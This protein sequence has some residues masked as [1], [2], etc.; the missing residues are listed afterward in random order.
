MH[1]IAAG[2]LIMLIAF[3]VLSIMGGAVV[4][5][6]PE[7]IRGELAPATPAIGAV[8]VAIVCS[9][10]C[11][12][13]P[14][15]AFAVPLL[16]L[17]L[18]GLGI[19]LQRQRVSARRPTNWRRAAASP[20]MRWLGAAG[21]AACAPI[22]LASVTA[23]RLGTYVVSQPTWSNDAFYYVSVTDWLIS[24]SASGSPVI[25][26][27]GDDAV[28]PGYGP[29][30]SA[31]VLG[32]RFSHEGVLSFLTMFTGQP[33]TS[34]WYPL[35][36]LWLALVPGSCAAAFSLLRLSRGHGLIAGVVLS[37][38]AAMLTQM[39]NQNS[40]SLLGLCIAPLA[41]S[42]LTRMLRPRRGDT[43]GAIWVYV[44]IAA[45]SWA[46]IVAVY[47]E[48]LPLTAGA[49][50]MYI[51]TRLV[52]AWRTVGVPLLVFCAATVG[53]APVAAA[54]FLKQLTYA[55]QQGFG[56]GNDFFPLDQPVISAARVLG[57]RTYYETGV[58]LWAWVL[59]A[60]V[61]AGLAFAVRYTADRVLWALL[62]MNVALITVQL[63]RGDRWYSQQRAIEVGTPIVLF[64]VLLGWAHWVAARR[65]SPRRGRSPALRL[66]TIAALGVAV[67]VCVATVRAPLRLSRSA[68]LAHRHV[69][70]AF[71]QVRDWVNQRSPDGEGVVVN[72]TDFFDQLWVAYVLR[73][74]DAVGYTVLYPDYLREHSFA[75]DGTPLWA[76]MDADRGQR[77]GDEPGCAAVETN[78]R[79]VLL[80]AAACPAALRAD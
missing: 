30:V 62:P 4:A 44:G 58:P 64:V 68:D 7:P 56:A 76:V 19:G 20:S 47:N 39:Y 50:A 66:R 18:S 2:L 79:F 26:P 25:A 31:L 27:S 74:D 73:Q 15:S 37:V 60:A 28:A 43:A 34:T 3:V 11:W 1:G 13:L 5:N 63:A 71:D 46:G 29:A 35:T 69:D 22:A 16:L 10:L 24:R 8:V 61:A 36:V 59:F 65:T 12:T 48:L 21:A 17:G 53:L 57:V 33:P 38:S 51:A 77:L 40:A 32:L 23:A 55:R 70:G 54:Q 42:A 41:I 80:D 75:G 14:V 49:G 6:L 45:T 72:V 78:P 52:A 67:M 9:T